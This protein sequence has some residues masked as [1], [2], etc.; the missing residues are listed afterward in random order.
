MID[1]RGRDRL[2]FPYHRDS[3]YFSME[4]TVYQLIYLNT[5]FLSEQN[6][7]YTKTIIAT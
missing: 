4:D 6:G 5:D 7:D 1:Q 2:K 3:I